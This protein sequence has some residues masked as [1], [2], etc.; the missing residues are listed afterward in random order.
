MDR[1]AALSAMLGSRI[2]RSALT[3]YENIT[4]FTVPWQQ[5]CE[6][7]TWLGQ[8]PGGDACLRDSIQEVLGHLE[9]SEFA[10]S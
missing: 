6:P 9:S 7:L 10:S 8:L 5:A 4:P 1:K 2:Q 3:Q